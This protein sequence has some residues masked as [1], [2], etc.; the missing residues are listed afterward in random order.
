MRIITK[1]DL[2]SLLQCPRKVWLDHST[3]DYVPQ[4]S[5]SLYRRATDGRIVAEKARSQLGSDVIWPISD[6][7]KAALNEVVKA[8]LSQ[9]P[10]KPAAEVPMIHGGLYARADALIPEGEGYV[11]RETK[12]STFKLKKRWC[13]ACGSQ[14]PSFK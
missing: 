1:S 3:P 2:Q 8:M 5:F 14:R 12:A 6:E 9:S 10:Q 13:S 7:G 4:N 11:L